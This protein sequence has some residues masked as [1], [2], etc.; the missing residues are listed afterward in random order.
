MTRDNDLESIFSELNRMLII[1]GFSYET[2]KKLVI[3]ISLEVCSTIDEDFLNLQG[4]YTKNVTQYLKQV[5]L[6][7]NYEEEEIEKILT[8]RQWLYRRQYVEKFMQFRGMLIQQASIRHYDCTEQ[9]IN[10]KIDYVLQELG[11]KKNEGITYISMRKIMYDLIGKYKNHMVYCWTFNKACFEVGKQYGILPQYLANCIRK[12][13]KNYLKQ[14]N[15][16]EL[17]PEDISTKKFFHTISKHIIN[18]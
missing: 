9:G 5:M 16:L 3:M 12:D 18:Y 13:I 15:F 1:S 2:I 4:V 6:E 8:Y 10:D 7:Q 14:Y 11:F 17:E